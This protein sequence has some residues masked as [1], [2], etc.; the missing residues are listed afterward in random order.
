MRVLPTDWDTNNWSPYDYSLE[1]EGDN[2]WRIILNTWEAKLIF[3]IRF[4]YQNWEPLQARRCKIEFQHGFTSHSAFPSML[5]HHIDEY[6]AVQALV[7]DLS[8]SIEYFP[9][10]IG[11]FMTWTANKARSLTTN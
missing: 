9:L 10:E 3:P 4:Q 5:W 7:M 8:D 11:W 2:K 6:S 1:K